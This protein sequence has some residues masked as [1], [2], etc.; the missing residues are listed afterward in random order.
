MSEMYRLRTSTVGIQTKDGKTNPVVIPSGAV[1]T[2]PNS[3][4]E[5]GRGSTVECVWHGD[6]V[7]LLTF[8]LRER[9]TRVEASG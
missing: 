3:P 7:E 6:V 2:V 5:Q 9:G 1:L 4:V 8:D